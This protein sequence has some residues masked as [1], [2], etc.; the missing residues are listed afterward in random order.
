MLESVSNM[1]GW[2]SPSHRAYI[3]WTCWCSS[4]ASSGW[5][6]LSKTRP[7]VFLVHLIWRSSSGHVRSRRWRTLLYSLSVSSYS[8]KCLAIRPHSLIA[9]TISSRS[10]DQTIRPTLVFSKLC[11]VFIEYDMSC[12]TDHKR[13]PRLISATNVT[14]VERT[15]R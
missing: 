11:V 1:C 2:C 13:I 7:K 9:R 10:E 4:M 15:T 6:L 12:S 14:E 5:L 3:S 8:P